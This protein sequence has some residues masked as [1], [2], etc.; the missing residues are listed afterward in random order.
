MPPIVRAISIKQPFVEKILRG[1]KRYEYRN[2]KTTI[3]ERVYL[4]A[5]LTPRKDKEA[6]RG[7]DKLPSQLAKGLIVGSVEI[8]DCRPHSVYGYAY[9]FANPKRLRTPLKPSNQPSPIFWRPKF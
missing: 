4:Y 2:V 7:M 9:K 3:R 8:V 5:S 6:W 1:T